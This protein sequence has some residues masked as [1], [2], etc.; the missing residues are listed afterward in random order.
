M[1]PV[2]SFR[3]EVFGKASQ[4]TAAGKIKEVS[5][6]RSYISLRILFLVFLL[7]SSLSAQ[8]DIRKGIKLGYNRST[9][10][11][12]GYSDTESLVKIGAGISVELSLMKLLF[13]Q[14]DL[15]Y[16]PQGVISKENGMSLETSVNYLSIPVYLKLRFFP[17]GVH[18]YLLGGMDYAFLLSADLDGHDMKPV[19]KSRDRGIIAGGG[20]E[21]TLLGKSV[22]V[23]GRYIHGI[24][25]IAE[26]G[27][28][29]NN[30]VYQL[31][32]GL[33]L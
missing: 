29:V 15:L 33:L 26:S 17:F 13:I 9:L 2:L 6:K 32:A 5:L 14:G 4:K 19:F 24:G 11:G 22:Y 28:E 20:L 3:T 31:Y 27:S 21:F 23:E 16:S 1:I 10:S 8:I 12:T 7:T 30:R 25:N 18:P